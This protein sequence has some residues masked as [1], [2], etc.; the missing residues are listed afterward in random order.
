MVGR[1]LVEDTKMAVMVTVK[2]PW[3]GQDEYY[4]EPG[5]IGVNISDSGVLSVST[6]KKTKS[7][8]SRGWKTIT[9]KTV[10]PQAKV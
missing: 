6:D 10:S 7:Y 2:K 3:W 9:S 1:R 4:G 5:E 8:S